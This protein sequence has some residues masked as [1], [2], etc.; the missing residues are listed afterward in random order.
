[1]IPYLSA[2]ELG[3]IASGLY[4]ILT[5]IAYVHRGIP[6]WASRVFFAATVFLLF[7]SKNP[8]TA[9]ILDSSD[10]KEFAFIFAIV[11]GVIG[12]VAAWWRGHFD[13]SDDSSADDSDNDN[14][15]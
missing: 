11:V 7:I 5:L 3:L 2:S 13:R 8:V 1:M 14:N 15:E 12:F 10:A 6:K 9:Y 4:S